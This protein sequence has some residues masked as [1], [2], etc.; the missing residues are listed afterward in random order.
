MAAP[1]SFPLRVE[2]SWGSYPPKNLSTK[3]QMYFQSARRSGGGE[4]EVRQEPG[5]AT[6]FLAFFH[7]DAV[8]QRVLETKNHELL[9]PGIG[10]FQLTVQLP[11]AT[12]EV[13][14]VL[15][16]DIPAKESETKAHIQEPGKGKETIWL[17]FAS[18]FAFIKDS[19]CRAHSSVLDFTKQR[20][21]SLEM[22]SVSSQPAVLRVSMGGAP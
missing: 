22:P 14:D 6:R 13:Q 5:T 2:G 19:P 3:L 18:S 4:C 21:L 17:T 7:L 8:R 15:E 16:G 1:G 11:T 20:V 12:E 9:W 10:T